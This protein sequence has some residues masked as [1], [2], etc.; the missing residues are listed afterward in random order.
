VVPEVLKR[1]ETLLTSRGVSVNERNKKQ[2]ELPD[3]C[4]LLPNS[5]GSAQGMWFKKDGRDFI[6][7]PGVPYEMK[8]IFKEELKSRLLE[9]FVLPAILHVTVLTHGIPESEMAIT[10]CGWEKNLPEN[11]KLAYLPSPGLLRLRLTGKTTGDSA[12]LKATIDR[13]VEKLKEIIGRHIFGYDDDKLEVIVGNLLKI[14]N[15]TLSLAESCT[16]GLISLM[17]TS[18]PG[19]SVYYKGGL[20]AYSNDLK[21]TE[22]NVSPYTLMINGAVSQAVVEQMADGARTRYG[23]DYSVA[24]SGIAGPSGGTQEK[25]VGTT[26]IAVASGRRIISRVFNFGEDRGRNMQKAAIAALFMLREEIM[27]GS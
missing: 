17:I 20:V 14:N 24:V 5:A 19:S 18:V 4:E 15:L 21:T 2:A 11:I 23:S 16:G 3:N 13:E 8:A 27:S 25:P 26:W 10:I 9:R 6:S 22:L 1:I 7:L 12:E